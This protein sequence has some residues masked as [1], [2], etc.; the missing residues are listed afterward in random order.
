MKDRKLYS[1][2]D[3]PTPFQ[4]EKMWDAIAGDL[5]E[6]KQTP[7]FHWKSFWIGNAA[8][9]LLIFAGIGMYS[10]VSNLG[11]SDTNTTEE[12]MFEALNAA[13]QKLQNVTPLLIQQAQEQNKSSIEST[14]DAIEE[15]DRLIAEIKAD[16]NLNGTSPAKESSLKRLYATKLD[17]YKEILLNQEEQS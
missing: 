10:T 12:Q 4:K 15:I 6:V 16:I 2:Q 11:I 8:A 7:V 14:A 9:I 3:F 17:F 1:D 13:T 5:S